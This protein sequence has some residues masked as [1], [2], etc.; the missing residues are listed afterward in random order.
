MKAYHSDQEAAGLVRY[1]NDR[2]ELIFTAADIKGYANPQVS[3]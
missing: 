1:T 3:G 2:G